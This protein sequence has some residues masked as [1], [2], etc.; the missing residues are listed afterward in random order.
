VRLRREVGSRHS[1]AESLALL[2][3]VVSVHGDHTAAYALYE[4]SLAIG[5][6]L[7]NVWLI[8]PCLD[9][10]ASLGARQGEFVRAARL[11]GAAEVLR[12]SVGM[13]IA[14]FERADYEQRVAAARAKLGAEAFA[15]AWAQGRT[16]TPEQALTMQGSLSTTIVTT[17]S[18]TYPAGLTAREVGVLR[19]VA[20][21]LTN[22][23]IAKELRLSEKTIAHHLT[24]IFNKTTSENRAAAAAFAIRHKLA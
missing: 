12:E 21:G 11:W 13:H 5:R 1:T 2:A 9:G 24:H 6:D 17:P 20:R 19:L 14:P 22:S 23:E 4:E 15:S 8:V 7:N 10:L 16:M 3:R 18:S